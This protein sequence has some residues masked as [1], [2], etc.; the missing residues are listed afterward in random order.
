[1][2]QLKDIKPIEIIDVNF[3]YYFIILTIFIIFVSVLIYFIFYKKNTLTKREKIIQR[4]NN[5]D[6]KSKPH[7]DIAYMFTLYG[8]ETLMDESKNKFY[9]ILSKLE[10]YK[11]KKNTTPLPINLQKEI[12][13]YI[14]ELV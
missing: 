11:Y 10:P 6:F 13:K 8:K 7:K 9:N 2:E 3:L 14:D 4:L 12:K 1:M 5:I